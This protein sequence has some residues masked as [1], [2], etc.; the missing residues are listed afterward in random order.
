M[1]AGAGSW[2]EKPCRSEELENA[3]DTRSDNAQEDVG[4]IPNIEQS[5]L[6][7]DEPD[8]RATTI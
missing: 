7:I 8:A 5:A 4:V 3:D 2:P 6:E 1:H